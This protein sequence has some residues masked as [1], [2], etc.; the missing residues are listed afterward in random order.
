MG[1]IYEI[2][3]NDAHAMTMALMEKAFELEPDNSRFLLELDQ[4]SARNNVPVEKRLERLKKYPELVKERDVLYLEYITLLNDT[5]QYDE[6]LSCLMSHQFHPWEGGEGRVIG[7]YRYA[8]TWKALQEMEKGCYEQ[9]I[10]LLSRTFAYP[11]NLGEG[12]LPNVQDTVAL[13]YTGRCLAS[14]G[15]KEEAEKYF[16]MASVGLNEPSAVLYY[17][18]QSSET[19]LYQGLAHL[20]LSDTRQAKKAFHQLKYFGEQHMFDTISHDYF[21]VSLPELEVFPSDMQKRNI[22]YCR[23]LTALGELG[24]GNYHTAASLLD[25]VLEIQA[26][27]QGCLQ[28]KLLLN[29][30]TD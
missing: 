17:N 9:A 3:G 14:L 2:F 12:K 18:D 19:I 7:Q 6:A 4:V 5:C 20:A 26:D 10:E 25:S 11:E 13:Y 8:L 21:A 29:Q 24:L 16:R 28:H 15:K 22:C 1:K 27:H 30:F 23:Y